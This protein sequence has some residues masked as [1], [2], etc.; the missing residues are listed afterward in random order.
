MYRITELHVLHVIPFGVSGRTILHLV[1]KLA[2][3]YRAKLNT[4]YSILPNSE[5]IFRIRLP[6][7]NV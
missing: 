5:R 3:I 7:P 6:Q 2:K 1:Q 4:S